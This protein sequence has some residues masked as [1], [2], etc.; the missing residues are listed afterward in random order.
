MGEALKAI[1]SFLE[2]NFRSVASSIRANEEQSSN[3]NLTEVKK[4]VEKLMSEDIL[5]K[6]YNPWA[7][8]KD[9]HEDYDVTITVPVSSHNYFGALKI[10]FKW[11]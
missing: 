10:S 3:S 1:Q 2:S 11:D 4:E 9:K 6:K 5:R 7:S 8:C